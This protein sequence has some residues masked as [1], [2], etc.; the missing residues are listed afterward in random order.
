[1]DT[2]SYRSIE[3]WLL[4]NTYTRGSITNYNQGVSIVDANDV[5]GQSQQ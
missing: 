2:K 5:R 4:D 3:G 1:M